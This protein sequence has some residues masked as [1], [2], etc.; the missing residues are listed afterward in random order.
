MAHIEKLKV[1]K[2]LILEHQRTSEQAIF[3]QILE[4]VE[5]LLLLAIFH[6]FRWTPSLQGSDLQDLYQTSILGLYR[7][8]DTIEERDDPNAVPIRIMACVASEIDKMYG[9][10]SRE[11]IDSHRFLSIKNQTISDKE[12]FKDLEMED[13][14][15]M[16]SRLIS[17]EVITN[18]EF[19]MVK[20]KFVDGII[21]KEI[22]KKFGVVQST[23]SSRISKTLI[24][25]KK[26]I[27]LIDPEFGGF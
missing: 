27:N 15:R 20:L 7:A 25:M 21:E 16:F 23:V 6:C 19:E 18:E 8:I 4:R 11:K 10:H 2:N 12:M 17:E 9:K 13:T 5:G 22:A 26:A 1:I 3:I 24:K 14:R